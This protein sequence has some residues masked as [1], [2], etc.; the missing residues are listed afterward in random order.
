MPKLM[1]G[2]ERVR[3]GRNRVERRPRSRVA[4]VDFATCRVS[5]ALAADLRMSHLMSAQRGFFV[6]G[7]TGTPQL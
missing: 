6:R 1:G 4:G 7:Q 5:S 2:R 3:K